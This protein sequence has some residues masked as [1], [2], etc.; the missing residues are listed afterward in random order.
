MIGVPTDTRAGL[1]ETAHRLIATADWDALAAAAAAHLDSDPDSAQ[2]WFLSAVSAVHRNEIAQAVSDAEMALSKDRSIREIVE[3]LAALYIFVGDLT[4]ALFHGKMALASESDPLYAAWFPDTL[5][6]FGEALATVREMPLLDRAVR[7]TQDGELSSA[8]HWLRQHL[9]FN[10]DSRIAHL[11]LGHC[12]TAV[13]LFHEALDSLRASAHA[14]PGDPEVLGQMASALAYA[15][16]PDEARAVGRAARALAPDDAALHLRVL[17]TRIND[18]EEP[19]ADLARAVADWSARFGCQPE[20]WAIEPTAGSRGRLTIGYLIGGLGIRPQGEAVADIIAAHDNERLRL[21]GFGWGDLTLQQNLK[22]QKCFDTW[23]DVRNL[24][25]ITLGTMVAAEAIDILVDLSGYRS[26]ELLT[27]FGTRMA[28]VQV[29]WQGSPAGTGMAT[30]DALLTDAVL[31]PE[32][33][34]WPFREPPVRL[35][36]GLHPIQ[37]PADDLPRDRAAGEDLVLVSNTP[38]E[39]LSPSTLALWARVLLAIPEATLVL[40]DY[41]HGHPRVIGQLIDLF[42]NFGLA[43]RIDLAAPDKTTDLYRLGD[44]CLPPLLATEAGD[45]AQALWQGVPV[46]ALKGPDRRQRSV[47]RLLIGLGLDELVADDADSYVAIAAAWARDPDRRAAFRDDIRGRMRDA[48]LFDP[49]R[50]A[51]DL[52]QAYGALWDGARNRTAC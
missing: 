10:P 17:E 13:G 33:E 29:A 51:Q 44:L 12:L 37:L 42:G 49:R 50:R 23:H 28:P 38:L 6:T 30:I 14:L 9:A 27:A 35:E 25:P 48:P 52:E 26:P 4:Q 39:F 36:H 47:A 7:A 2:A 46:V 43:H 5:A 24:D 1:A 3:L 18:P 19:I 32:E 21:V 11:A 45:A 16:R 31:D 8:V 34:P 41:A 40:Q 15:G 22:F 20:P